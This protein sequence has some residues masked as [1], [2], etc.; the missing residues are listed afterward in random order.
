MF[1]NAELETKIAGQAY[2]RAAQSLVGRAIGLPMT[3]TYADLLICEEA[4]SGVQDTFEIDSL[5]ALLNWDG[6]DEID[7]YRKLGTVMAA[8]IIAET[9]FHLRRIGSSKI[10]SEGQ[11]RFRCVRDCESSYSQG[12]DW[13]C[14]DRIAYMLNGLYGQSEDEFLSS[15]QSDAKKLIEQHW[16]EIAALSAHLIANGAA[17]TKV[18]DGFIAAG[19]NG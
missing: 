2:R 5:D 9:E 11:K 14:L 6:C 10:E 18:I 16:A 19:G 1:K 4:C 8:G 12:N 15:S 7:V 17:S 3:I 13:V